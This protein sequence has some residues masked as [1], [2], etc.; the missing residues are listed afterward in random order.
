[1][2]VVQSKGVQLKELEKSCMGLSKS[3]TDSNSEIKR[4]VVNIHF[5]IWTG[6][7]LWV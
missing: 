3:Y 2:S 7:R 6:L 5:Y 1:M 4:K